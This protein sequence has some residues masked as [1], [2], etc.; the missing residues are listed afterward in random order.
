MFSK[1]GYLKY[2]SSFASD[3][4]CIYLCEVKDESHLFDAEQEMVDYAVRLS[5]STSTTMN[6]A[7]AGNK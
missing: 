2:L 3:T 1:Q 6:V 4:V 7:S 5:S